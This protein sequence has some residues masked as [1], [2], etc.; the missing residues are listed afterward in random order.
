MIGCHS[1][2]QVGWWV[3]DYGK[4]LKLFIKSGDGGTGRN[5]NM[6]SLVPD[7]TRE[8]CERKWG[9]S[10]LISRRDFLGLQR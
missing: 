2:R 7:G 4:G 3:G 1:G 5:M 8:R 10:R 6:M 9:L